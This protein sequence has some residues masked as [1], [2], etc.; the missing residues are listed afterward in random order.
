M[1]SSLNIQ[2]R[3]APIGFSFSFITGIKIFV[4]DSSEQTVFVLLGDV[5]RELTGKHASE[6]V[7][8]YFEVT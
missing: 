3:F 5:G 8:S 1:S 4:C 6:L 7:N 2:L